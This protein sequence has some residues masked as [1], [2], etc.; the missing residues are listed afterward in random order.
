MP[1]SNEP[2]SLFTLRPSPNMAAPPLP[3]ATY[4]TADFAFR[5]SPDVDLE[6]VD[7][8][9]PT[10]KD[11]STLEN[12]IHL[13]IQTSHVKARTRRGPP[14]LLIL[15]LLCCPAFVI[16]AFTGRA[17]DNA[18]CLPCK[19]RRHAPLV[20]QIFTEFR[21]VPHVERVYVTQERALDIFRSSVSP[22]SRNRKQKYNTSR[23]GYHA[24]NVRDYMRR[25][26]PA[27]IVFTRLDQCVSIGHCPALA[28]RRSQIEALD[29][30]ER[31]RTLTPTSEVLGPMQKPAR[32]LQLG[33]GDRAF[34]D[35]ADVQSAVGL[36]TAVDALVQSGI[37]LR[38]LLF[39][40]VMLGEAAD[41]QKLSRYLYCYVRLYWRVSS[42]FPAKPH[43]IPA[44][45]ATPHFFRYVYPTEDDPA[46]RELTAAAVDG[47]FLE[48]AAQILAFYTWFPDCGYGLHWCNFSG[49]LESCWGTTQ[50]DLPECFSFREQGK[51]KGQTCE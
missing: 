6:A 42:L 35:E 43:R 34:Q 9:G 33:E 50:F 20:Q 30:Y 23:V 37:N 26:Y 48:A 38:A 51:L 41:L 21:N 1:P 29:Y 11:P 7:L 31:P 28:R 44:D 27:V 32:A 25:S 36:L 24:A 19:P 40:A 2:L 12:R 3:R 22:P 39:S 17:P 46:S 18:L 45:H 5:S 14:V 10:E 15:L 13:P 8:Y 16:G 4:H 47:D 49:V